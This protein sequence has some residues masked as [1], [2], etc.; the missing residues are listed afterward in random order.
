MKPAFKKYR[1][2]VG[3][4]YN[5][6]HDILIRMDM[7]VHVE[8][9]GQSL[10]VSCSINENKIVDYVFDNLSIEAFESDLKECLKG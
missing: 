6:N 5:S 3:D 1:G 10:T 7:V 2:R 8:Q 9:V 4:G